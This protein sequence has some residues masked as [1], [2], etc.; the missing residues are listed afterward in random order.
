MTFQEY[1]VRLSKS[2]KC[3]VQTQTNEN[4]H[5]FVQNERDPNVNVWRIITR[6]RI[7]CGKH[8]ITGVTYLNASDLFTIPHIQHENV[9]VE[10]VGP[11]PRYTE[12]R[13]S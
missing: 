13:F 3:G 6:D 4:P 9:I 11:P 2:H 8:N 12:Y 7:V 5:S 1:T 10:Q